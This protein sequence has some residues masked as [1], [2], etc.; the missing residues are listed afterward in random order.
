MKNQNIL[1]SVAIL[2]VGI[3]LGFLV[4]GGQTSSEKVGVT[5]SM[6]QMPDGS[7][8]E[9][10]DMEDMMHGMMKGL[11]GKTGDAFD[12]EF[13]AEMIIHHQG[14]VDMAK[15]VLATSKRPELIKLANDIISAQTNEILM[16]QNWQ[17]NWFK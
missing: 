5:G 8:M 9:G 11:E 15:A 1:T 16:M 17:K 14:A 6:H 2:A 3:F 10:G 13:L 4:F 7:M 12:K